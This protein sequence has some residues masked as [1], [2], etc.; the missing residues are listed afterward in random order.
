[1]ACQI[2]KFHV[3]ICI[4]TRNWEINFILLGKFSLFLNWEGMIIP[5]NLMTY[6][7]LLLLFSH[8]FHII[9]LKGV[10]VTRILR[11]GCVSWQ[12][13]RQTRQGGLGA[14]YLPP[15]CCIHDSI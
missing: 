7:V 13:R 14:K 15:C 9:P 10:N 8:P 6:N 2:Q 4:I 5:D 3:S 11:I 12:N 1:M